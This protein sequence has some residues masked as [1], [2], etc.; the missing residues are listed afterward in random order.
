MNRFKY[1]LGYFIGVCTSTLVVLYALHDGY[2]NYTHNRSVAADLAL[3]FSFFAW[4]KIFWT[5]SIINELYMNEIAKS[6]EKEGD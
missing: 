5:N 4:K 2:Q 6:L 1:N 3:L